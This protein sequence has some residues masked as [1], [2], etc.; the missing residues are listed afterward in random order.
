VTE[1]LNADARVKMAIGTQFVE[2]QIMQDRIDD[3]TAQLADHAKQVADRDAKIAKL[4]RAGKPARKAKPTA[5][6]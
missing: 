6:A 5:A 3:L 4:E 2:I 1:K